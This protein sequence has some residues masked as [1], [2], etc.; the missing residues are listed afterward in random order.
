[1]KR[2]TAAAAAGPDAPPGTAKEG[3]LGSSTSPIVEAFVTWLVFSAGAAI[4]LYAVIP[5]L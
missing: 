1:V 5:A 2:F 3:L 4:I